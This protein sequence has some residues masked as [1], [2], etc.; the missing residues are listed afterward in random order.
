MINCFA[1][2]SLFSRFRRLLGFSKWIHIR[3]PAVFAQ[4][5]SRSS[6]NMTMLI[7]KD[8]HRTLRFAVAALTAATILS[9]C[10][11]HVVP[12]P[13]PTA[14]LTVSP[15]TIQRG[16]SA[17][18]TWQTTNATDIT[19]DPDIG[20]VAVLGTTIVNPLQTTTYKITAT[21]RGGTAQASATLTV[22]EP[23]P[24]PVSPP[25]SQREGAIR[26]AD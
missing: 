10:H 1:P 8:T 7:P 6:V 14:A 4:P 9:S 11:K 23:Q 22:T 17:R 18:L 20:K 13:A 3:A 24:K 15:D 12:P 19:I 16:H 25:L 5:Q 26:P 21:G 2:Y